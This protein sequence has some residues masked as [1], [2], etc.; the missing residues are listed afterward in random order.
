VVPLWAWGNL[1]GLIWV[2]YHNRHGIAYNQIPTS[3]S[4]PQIPVVQT[5]AVT[6]PDGASPGQLLQVNLPGGGNFQTP[7]PVG[8]MPGQQFLVALPAASKE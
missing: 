1:L 2:A 4:A 5:L 3:T 7:V 8:A 6:V